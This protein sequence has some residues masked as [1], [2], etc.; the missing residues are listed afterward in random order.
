MST[1]ALTVVVMESDFKDQNATNKNPKK[2]FRKKLQETKV[3]TLF[4]KKESVERARRTSNPKL[5]KK[6]KIST[7]LFPLAKPYRK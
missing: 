4:R 1:C 6:W 5:M 7:L 2:I 3:T